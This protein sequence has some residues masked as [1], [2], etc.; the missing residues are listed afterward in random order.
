MNRSLSLKMLTM[1]CI[2]MLLASVFSGC[3]TN[4]AKQQADGTIPEIPDR[5]ER[6][7]DDVPILKVYNTKT[8]D[9]EEMDVES[10]IMGVVAGEMKNSWPIEALK[11]QAILARTFTMKFIS[12]KDSSYAGA[13]ISTDVEEAQAYDADAVND[14][15]REAVNETRGQVMEADGEFPYAWFHAHSGGMTEVPSKAL[16][17]NTDPDYLSVVKSEESPDAPEDVQSWT[18]EFTLEEASNACANTGVQVGK[19]ESF[20]IDERGESGRAV[21]FLVNGEKVSAPSFRLQIGAAKLKSTLIEK[22]ELDD[23]V[24]RFFGSGFGHGVGM[25]QWGAYQ[26]AKDDKSAED[27]I[28][29]YYSNVNIVKLW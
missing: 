22:I 10:Y 26:M 21:T 14:R 13:D 1:L 29:H 4:A 6:N 17:Y 25:S 7:D 27:I 18:V 24:I 11:A 5:L 8:S 28:Q 15:I 9:V 20:E 16:E 2:V 19:I 12:T 3:S 23:D